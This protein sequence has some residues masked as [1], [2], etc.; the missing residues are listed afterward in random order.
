MTWNQALG[1]TLI[2]PN[3]PGGDALLNLAFA[4]S[5]AVPRDRQV[6]SALVWTANNAGI[7]GPGLSC[8]ITE[9]VTVNGVQVSGMQDV[10]QTNVS[11]IG[12]HFYK[13]AGWGGPW[14]SAPKTMIFTP[15]DGGVIGRQD[16][17]RAD[18]VMT[19]PVAGGMLTSLPS[20]TID[21]T[22]TCFPALRKTVTITPGTIISATTCSVT[23]PSITVTL[24]S[25]PVETLLPV[26]T[27]SAVA[28]N[29]NI[30]LSCSPGA[31]V[32]VTLTDAT[33]PSNI[34]NNLT[35]TPASSAHGIA[36][37]LSLG[38]TPV[39]FGADSAVAGNPGQR[40]VGASSTTTGVGLTVQYISVGPVVP[41]SVNAIA[42]FT[43]SY[44]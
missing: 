34:T 22:G 26:G 14:T 42:T 36:L 12:V 29:F 15:P 30:G 2:F 1:G 20:M 9:T 28:Q 3:A 24:P 39:E 38:G 44:Q 32:Y 6:G 11:G 7:G 35:L 19:G 13:T 10:Y 18:L 41:G 27:A 8:Q 5:I 25:V 21:F 23:T 40:L 17:I 31:N 33:N 37:R 4:P 16:F 43:M